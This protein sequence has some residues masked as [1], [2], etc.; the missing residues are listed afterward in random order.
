MLNGIAPAAQITITLLPQGSISCD[1]AVPNRMIFNMMLE[2]GK[3]DMLAKMAEAEAAAK[4][5]V[6]QAPPGL[7]LG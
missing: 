3:Q 5:G 6:V 2:T 7:K 1:F 4:G